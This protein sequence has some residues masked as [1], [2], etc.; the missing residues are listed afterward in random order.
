MISFSA[1][2]SFPSLVAPHLARKMTGCRLPWPM[3]D[4]AATPN[5][6]DR[7]LQLPGRQRKHD[8]HRQILAAAECTAN[9]RIDHADHVFRQTKGMRDRPAVGV[10]PLAGAG[11]RDAAFL[12]D[13]GQAGLRLQVRMLL[14]GRPILAFDDHV[15]LGKCRSPHRLCGSCSERRRCVSPRSGCSSGALGLHRLHGIARTGR[16]SY[17]TWISRQAC[18]CGRFAVRQPRP[19]PGRRQSARC[20]RTAWMSRGRTRRADPESE[21][22]IRSQERPSPCRPQRRLQLVGQTGVDAQH[23][24]CGRSAKRIFMNSMPGMDRSPE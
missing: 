24:A 18:L 7:S 3:I 12:V 19:R 15:G 22:R 8:L 6:L 1:A 2:T 20:P 17:S 4:F 23:A 14:A 13:I 9:G 21:V 10:R 11:N 5:D 16:S